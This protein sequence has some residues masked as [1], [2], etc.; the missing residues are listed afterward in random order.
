MRCDLVQGSMRQDRRDS[1]HNQRKPLV[2]SGIGDQRGWRWRRDRAV[3]QG[4]Y[5]SVDSNEP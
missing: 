4:W 5:R 1:F 3:D 2:R